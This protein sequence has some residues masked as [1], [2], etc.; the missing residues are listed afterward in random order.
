MTNFRE[1]S[2]TPLLQAALP[3][4]GQPGREAGGRE[5]PEAAHEASLHLVRVQARHRGQAVQ[6]TTKIISVRPANDL[7]VSTITWKAPNRH[8]AEFLSKNCRFSNF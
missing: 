5:V 2:L 3:R 8:R 6:V 7:S 4:R 1:I